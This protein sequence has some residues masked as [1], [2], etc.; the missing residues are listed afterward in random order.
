MS[1]AEPF[2]IGLYRKE[3][4]C[5]SEALLFE[6][7]RMKKILSLFALV[8]LLL[9][10]CG[11]VAKEELPESIPTKTV[12]DEISFT[13]DL[14]RTVV[15]QKCPDRVAAL[16][17][18]FAD[19]WCLAGGKDTLVAAANDAWTSFE[20]DLSTEVRDL[21]AIKQP[22]LEVL[23][24]AKPDFVLASCNTEA[25]LSLQH[26]FEEAGITVAY[27]DIQ[28][29][30][31]YLHMLDICTEI[32][33][34]RQSYEEN[35]LSVQSE[36]QQALARQDGSSPTVL[37]IRATGS[38]CKAK[39]SSDNVLGEMLYD[40]GCINVADGGVLEDLSIEGIMAT[41]P[42]YIFAV[43]Q[44]SN[45]SD[46]QKMIE[47]MLLANPAWK[48]LRAVCEDH[49][50]VLDQSLYNLKPNARWGEAYEGLAD[51]LYEK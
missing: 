6:R 42:D 9:I 43:L 22:N 7:K 4:L 48:S 19:V 32:T 36:I 8:A 24:A 15:V 31:D 34:E 30:S 18:S 1:L 12:E 51:I 37:C 35:G 29:F 46:A 5:Y 45:N 10:L 11:C 39:G 23:L 20:L 44:G 38:S 3:G 2:V 27:F 25:N 50:F 13:D 49:F 41:D 40:L 17:G 21:G 33:G 16:I 26:T 28:S 47:D 14:G